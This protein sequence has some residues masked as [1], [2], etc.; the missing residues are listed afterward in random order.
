[1]GRDMGKE[2]AKGDR[3]IFVKQF[4]NE[5]YDWRRAKWGFFRAFKLV[6]N[7]EVIALRRM[8]MLCWFILIPL[9]YKLSSGSSSKAGL[10]NLG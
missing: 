8:F 5:I 7:H 10:L 3:L 2:V 4:K 6:M 9:F 1:M